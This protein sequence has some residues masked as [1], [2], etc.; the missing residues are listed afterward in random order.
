MCVYFFFCKQSMV[1]IKTVP[2]QTVILN[3]AVKYWK[4]VAEMTWRQWKKKKQQNK[5]KKKHTVHLFFFSREVN[6]HLTTKASTVKMDNVQ[7]CVQWPFV[8]NYSSRFDTV[9]IKSYETL[10][11]WRPTCHRCS[12]DGWIDWGL[13][14]RSQSLF[15]FPSP[16]VSPLTRGGQTT[17]FLKG[18]FTEKNG[19]TVP[20][21]YFKTGLQDVMKTLQAGAG[22]RFGGVPVFPVW[23]DTDQQWAR[24]TQEHQGGWGMGDGGAGRDFWAATVIRTKLD[25]LSY[26]CFADVDPEVNVQIMD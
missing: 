1:L 9:R 19:S 10:C 15:V 17:V 7:N 6:Y 21:A 20:S 23:S 22:P 14:T 26:I 12:L 5:L 8:L 16:T 11:L 4:I 13:F 2:T 24:S 25:K 3:A 18:R